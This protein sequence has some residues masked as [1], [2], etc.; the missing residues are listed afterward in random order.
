MMDDFQMLEIYTRCPS[1]G[2]QLTEEPRCEV[3]G[4]T[5]WVRG[6]VVWC[7]TCNPS[8]PWRKPPAD[9]QEVDD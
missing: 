8:H 3:C 6:N 9:P 4:T 7:D 2:Y 5:M 1:C